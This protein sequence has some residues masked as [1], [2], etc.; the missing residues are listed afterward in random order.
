MY[1]GWL[2]TA[3]PTPTLTLSLL[4]EATKIPHCLGKQLPKVDSGYEEESKQRKGD[5][6]KLS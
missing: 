4:F 2:F 3:H 5:E 1:N 6:N